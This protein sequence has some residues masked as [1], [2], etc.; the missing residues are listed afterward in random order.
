MARRK[1]VTRTITATEV[2]CLCM[3][4]VDAE[5]MNKVFRVVGKFTDDDKLIK[6]VRKLHETDDFK[7]VA[8]VD[9]TETQELYGLDENEFLASAHVIARKAS[10]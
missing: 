8:I 7:I 2:N 9:K 4:I 10:K 6:V 1:L 3:N 5:P